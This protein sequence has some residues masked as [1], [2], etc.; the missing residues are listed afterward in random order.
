MK[1][2]IYYDIPMADY[3]AIDALSSSLAVKAVTES[4]RHALQ[5]S[6]ERRQSN[7]ADKGTVAH[8]LLLEGN[9]EGIVEIDAIDWRKNETKALRDEAYANGLIPLL[10]E[11]MKGVRRMVAA[12]KQYIELTELATA[13]ETG[14]PEATVIWEDNGILCK[15]RPDLLSEGFHVSVKTTEASAFPQ[16]WTRRVMAASG[17]DIAMQFYRRGLEANGV[18]VQHRFLVIEQ[19]PPF[20]TSIVGLEP[21]KEAICDVLVGDAIRIWGECLASN[22]FPAYPTT[23][24]W[25]EATPWELAEAEAREHIE[26]N[27]VGAKQ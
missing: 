3:L 11:Q 9:E 6:S 1:Q 15:C 12:A 13:F 24:F 14:R 5:Y 8:K 4:P 18:H 27:G 22:N 16:L 17:Y 19:K 26:V 10:S 7:V 25:A 20:G 2:G 21:S 23:T